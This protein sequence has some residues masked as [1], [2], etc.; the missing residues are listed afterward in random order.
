MSLAAKLAVQANTRR[1]GGARGT[2][3]NSG[4][5][6]ILE[7]RTQ[8]ITRPQSQC[9][10][11]RRTLVVRGVNGAAMKCGPKANGCKQG[12]AGGQQCACGA[13]CAPPSGT[14]PAAIGRRDVGA[15]ALARLYRDARAGPRGNYKNPC[16]PHGRQ[17]GQNVSASETMAQ[18]RGE[19]A[20][21]AGISGSD[22]SES[23]NCSSALLQGRLCNDLG[24]SVGAINNGSR[25]HARQCAALEV[26]PPL[27]GYGQVQNSQVKLCGLRLPT[28]KRQG[29]LSGSELVAMTA[30]CE[31]RAQQVEWNTQ[32]WCGGAA[33]QAA[34]RNAETTFL[35]SE[36]SVLIEGELTLADVE[37]AEAAIVVQGGTVIRGVQI[38]TAVTSI[39]N[40]SDDDTTA[41]FYN[42]TSLASVEFKDPANSQCVTIGGHAFRGCSALTGIDLDGIV[43]IG[44]RAFQGAGLESFTAPAS[45]SAIPNNICNSAGPLSTVDLSA[46]TGTT[47]GAGAFD[48]DDSEFTTITIPSTV[49][50][51][52]QNALQ[53]PNLVTVVIEANA[54]GDTLDIGQ[55]AFANCFALTTLTFGSGPARQITR[56]SDSFTNSGLETA[57][58]TG[59][60]PASFTVPL[61]TAI[62]IIATT[63]DTVTTFD[64]GTYSW[65][66]ATLNGS[67]LEKSQ[68]TIA[69]ALFGGNPT[70]IAIGN[71][72]TSI[73][74]NLA[75]DNTNLETLTF[76]GT[77]A[78]E[79]IGANAFSGCT[80]VTTIT[81]PN[82]VTSIDANAFDGCTSLATITGGLPTSL[83]TVGANAFDGCAS[84]TTITIPD[85]V[86]SIGANAFDGCTSLATLTIN[87]DALNETGSGTKAIGNEAFNDCPL[88]LATFTNGGAE[89]IIDVGSAGNLAFTAPA[90][91]VEAVA[92]GT[93]NQLTVANG[94]TDYTPG[95]I[96][97]G[98]GGGLSYSSATSITTDVVAAAIA[99]LY[100]ETLVGVEIGPRVT[101]IGMDAFFNDEVPGAGTLASLTFNTDAGA[102]NVTIGAS[103]FSATALTS[104]VLPARVAPTVPGFQIAAFSDCLSLASADLS[105][106]LG[107]VG[108]DMFSGCSALASCT[109]PINASN[110]VLGDNA[111]ENCTTLAS[112]GITHHFESIGANAFDGCTSLATLTVAFD[113]LLVT[114][115]GTKAIGDDAFNACPLNSVTFTSA[116][117]G[118]KTIEVG[119]GDNP[120]FDA[121]A[122]LVAAI[123][124]GIG[125]DPSTLEV[126]NGDE[127]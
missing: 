3:R 33:Q 28:V 66:T 2:P 24:G 56:Q 48:G 118:I 78:C 80:S 97:T 69:A 122:S 55:G 115:S 113:N 1:V 93:A 108:G 124:A 41:P 25:A 8:A 111:F 75:Q 103:A 45:L 39:G 17:W 105:A 81:L 121:P 117:G 91:L 51:I 88:T 15:A 68:H 44:I 64:D 47:I 85:T 126:T 6:P 84:L 53:G 20:C 107:D 70:T 52:L 120:A 114:S 72:V 98:N 49:T 23:Q 95:T 65:N 29:P 109:L 62:P 57:M 42:Q 46:Y 18:L 7:A 87:V 21:T 22:S 35:G 63:G 43:T 102:A 14:I 26:L 27:A 13:A 101:A 60:L 31:R 34:D 90:Q 40:A 86:T 36:Y 54:N 37:A 67:T 16:S 12:C 127:Y 106:L 61:N 104:L 73:G 110:R 99:E 96:F 10:P 32:H 74:S 125:A 112:I 5:A 59:N 100:P 19:A 77:S 30:D 119:T 38:G 94:S 79:T 92:D 9:Y 83:S 11:N 76:K 58:D 116:G 82:T 123:T 4:G 50:Q 71:T 89:R